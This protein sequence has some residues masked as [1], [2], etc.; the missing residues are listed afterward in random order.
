MHKQIKL[1]SNPPP[2]FYRLMILTQR[3]AFQT[4]QLAL[5]L[6]A[7]VM[8]GGPVE[9]CAMGVVLKSAVPK[10]R[11]GAC[12]AEIRN[13]LSRLRVALQYLLQRE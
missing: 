2:S 4:K 10:T 1:K 9:A 6:V 7:K 11:C 8:K 5:K 12:V 13:D 3:E